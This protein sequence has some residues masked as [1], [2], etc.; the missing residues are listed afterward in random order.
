[1]TEPGAG[2]RSAALLQV[3]RLLS[4][5]HA[6]QDLTNKMQAVV[7]AV[8]D[9]AGFALAALN[10]VRPTGDFEVVAVAGSVQA[11]E[12]LLGVVIP[13]STFDEEFAASQAWGRLRFIPHDRASS[14]QAWFW[15]PEIEPVEAADAWHPLDA[16]LAPLHSSDGVLIG[17]LSVDMPR[18]GRRPSVQQR[19]LLEVLATEAAVAL[20]NGMLSDQLRESES[21]FRQAFDGSGSGMALMAI[22]D[23][24]FGRFTRVNPA[25]CA[26]LGF[27]AEFLLTMTDQELTHVD[28]QADEDAL[29]GDL[30]AGRIDSYRREKRLRHHN[31]GHV[32]VAV[33]STITRNRDGSPRTG[34]SQIEDISATRMEMEALHFL[35]SHDALTQLPHRSAVIARL[36]ASVGQSRATGRPGAVMFLDVDDFKLIND[37]FG[38]ATGDQVLVMLADRIRTAVRADDL[39]GR[40]GGDE[41]V[42][43]ADDLSHVEARALAERI[44]AM[45]SAPYL[46]RSIVL[47]V[48]VSVGIAE[49]GSDGRDAAQILRDADH[50]MYLQKKSAAV[51]QG[52]LPPE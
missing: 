40:L 2:S 28:D 27:E 50:A 42:V 23:G 44:Q 19:G 33:T 15:D 9:S 11:R 43:I 30:M 22:E 36:T 13:A 4:G 38:H 46:S 1:M 48:T 20:H 34:V 32:W 49:I 25:L 51:P 45:V 37:R 21:I 17:V 12:D 6:E 14:P 29:V 47:S 7:D 39:V 8:V 18:D 24:R 10:T 35:A 16:L 26:V 3:Y 5:I 41:F 52:S 31:G